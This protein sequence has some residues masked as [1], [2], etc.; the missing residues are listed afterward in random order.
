MNESRD[1]AKKLGDIVVNYISKNK[2]QKL[3]NAFKKNPVL[4]K[5]VEEYSNAHD[6]WKDAHKRLMDVLEK[7]C[8]DKKC[9][10]NI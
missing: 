10:T 5:H 4:M 1:D 8:N 2:K 6:K 7:V 3:V 9:D